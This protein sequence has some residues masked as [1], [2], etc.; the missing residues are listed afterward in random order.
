MIGTEPVAEACAMVLVE[1]Y[2]SQ[3]SRRRSADFRIPEKQSYLLFN[4]QFGLA[5]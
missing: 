4:C 2:L 1:S 5:F 3:R